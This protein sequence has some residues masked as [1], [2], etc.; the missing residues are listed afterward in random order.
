M[1]SKP[2]ERTDA[3]AWWRQGSRRRGGRD[4]EKAKQAGRVLPKRVQRCTRGV[5]R[6]CSRR[7]ALGEEKAA[8][9]SSRDTRAANRTE[10][11]MHDSMTPPSTQSRLTLM[12][13]GQFKGTPLDQLPDEYLL[14]LITRDDLRDPLL[15][16]AQS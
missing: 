10:R 1:K 11:M 6:G 5:Q 16:G 15:H 2:Q 3:R 9:G 13:F 7:S 14:W 8:P 4:L 12:P